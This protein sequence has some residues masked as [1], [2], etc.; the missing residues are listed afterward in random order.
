MKL[1]TDFSL[2]WRKNVVS[3]SHQTELAIWQKSRNFPSICSP[4]L[5]EAYSHWA[6][7]QDPTWKLFARCRW[8]GGG[9]LFISQLHSILGWPPW[10]GQGC[11]LRGKPRDSLPVTCL[12]KRCSKGL[13]PP[14]FRG[15]WS[16]T[17]ISPSNRGSTPISL[18]T[19]KPLPLAWPCLT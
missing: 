3:S 6:L 14:P 11:L 15:D 7:C 18:H 16:L 13:F 19:C 4:H 8:E 9:D 2:P 5:P 10:L 17:I 1:V 12:K